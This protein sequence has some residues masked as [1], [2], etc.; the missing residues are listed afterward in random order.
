VLPNAPIHPTCGLPIPTVG[1]ACGTAGNSIIRH[2]GKVVDIISG[3]STEQAEHAPVFLKDGRVAIQNYDDDRGWRIMSIPEENTTIQNHYLRGGDFVLEWYNSWNH[4]PSSTQLGD[5]TIRGKGVNPT[6]VYI[7]LVEAN[8]HIA[9]GHNDDGLSLVAR[10]PDDPVNGMSAF[11][12]KDYNT[13]WMPGATKLAMAPT[14]STTFASTEMITNGT[15]SNG[16]TGWSGGSATLS[17]S[18]G[19]LTVTGTRTTGG[20]QTAVATVTGTTTP[21]E[22]YI[23]TFQII[24]HVANQSSSGIIVGNGEIV[25]NNHLHYWYPNTVGTHTTTIVATSTY[26]TLQLHAGTSVGVITKF[27]NVSLFRAEPDRSA[28]HRATQ[29]SG[30]VTRGAVA[31]GAE[32]RAYENFSSSNFMFQNYYNDELNFGTGDFAIACWVKAGS[33]N[34]YRRF[35]SLQNPSGVQTN[36]DAINIKFSPHGTNDQY[37]YAY[38]GST[39][40]TVN[41]PDAAINV[42]HHVVLTRRGNH[43]NFYLNGKLTD[44]KRASQSKGS[45]NHKLYIGK[46]AEGN[47]V[48][49]GGSITLIKIAKGTAPSSEQVA[50]MYRDELCMFDENSNIT[51]YGS[52]SGVRGL[53]HDDDTNLLHVGTPSGRS[54]FRGLRRVENTT[55]AVGETTNAAISASNGL[56]VENT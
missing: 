55:T 32:L 1:V 10:Q 39:D 41:T 45:T 35:I 40:G 53:A 7:P 36:E 25:E 50:R 18:G 44:T 16:T 5:I 29:I 37:I 28:R 30:S 38:L 26:L 14:D 33:T 49:T 31:T 4:A 43:Y 19:V 56:V 23:V 8:E 2:D 34:S 12:E 27:D 11:I 20:N 17:E 6:N 21:G 48:F 54:V 9:I 22:Q 52:D 15:F 51:L 13:G 3:D 42:W 47:E 46:G 24:E